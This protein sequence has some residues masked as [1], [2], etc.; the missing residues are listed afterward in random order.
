MERLGVTLIAYS[1]NSVHVPGHVTGQTDSCYAKQRPETNRPDR[2][3][4][5]IK[6]IFQIISQQ[7]PE[8]DIGE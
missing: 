1:G 8:Y 4:L 2:T 5:H 6:Y 3:F 7:R